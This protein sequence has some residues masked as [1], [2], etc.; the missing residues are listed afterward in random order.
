VN[1]AK[2]DFD[3]AGPAWVEVRDARGEVLVARTLPAGNRQSFTGI[4]PLSV[5]I[6]NS[7]L[8]KLRFNDAAVDL[9]PYAQR[10]IARLTL[11]TPR[12]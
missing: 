12:R 4:A 10:G 9:T 2:V 11:P 8:V 5:R 6:G 1:N 3:L 7:R